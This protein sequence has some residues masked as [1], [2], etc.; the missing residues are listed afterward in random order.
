MKREDANLLNLV[1]IICNLLLLRNSL[2]DTES[3]PR[4]KIVYL[5]CRNWRF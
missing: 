4:K 1:L 5:V 2:D 3:S